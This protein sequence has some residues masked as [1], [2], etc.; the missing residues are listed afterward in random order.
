MAQ[1][2]LGCV[3][4]PFTSEILDYLGAE[5]G[6]TRQ[7]SNNP[8]RRIRKNAEIQ[9]RSKKMDK[10]FG[11][12]MWTRLKQYEI[13]FIFKCSAISDDKKAFTQ[14]TVPHSFRE[15]V[16]LLQVGKHWKVH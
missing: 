3:Q 7:Q 1:V 2:H 13:I 16:R 5:L 14:T 9:T 8:T 6:M 15:S 10:S 11:V 4:L 12:S